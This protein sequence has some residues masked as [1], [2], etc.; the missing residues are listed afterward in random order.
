MLNGGSLLQLTF[1]LRDHV[2]S[3]AK[4][5]KG[6]AFLEVFL[7]F[8]E[9]G[10]ND[11]PLGRGVFVVGVRELGA[12]NHQPGRDN[13]L[14]ALES[15]VYQ[16]APGQP[17]LAPDAGGNGYLAL[18]LDFSGGVNKNILGSI[19]EVRNPDFCL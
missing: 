17:G 19:P 3:S 6:A 1:H 4:G 14:A 9:T 12:V 7:G 2:R 13:N 15:K 18:V 16:V 5:A 8:I 10:I 11:A